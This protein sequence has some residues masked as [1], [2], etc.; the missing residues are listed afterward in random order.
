MSGINHIAVW[1]A[2]IAHFM[3]GAGWYMTLA[4][5][6]LTGIGKT[7]AQIMT[8]QPNTAIPM[9]IGFAV[10]IIIAYTLAWLLP[11]VGAQSAGGGATTGATLAL[12]LVATTLAMNYGFEA[13]PVSLWLINSGYMVVGMAVM[14]GIIGGWRKKA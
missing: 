8:E 12:A 4:K 2:G 6:W 3:L 9:I 13:R 10:A 14:G 11:K 1:V 5:A 7:E